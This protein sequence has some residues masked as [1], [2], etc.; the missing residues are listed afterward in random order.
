MSLHLDYSCTIIGEIK[1]IWNCVSKGKHKSGV[2]PDSSG[3]K[4]I[5][6][7]ITERLPW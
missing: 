7:N 6:P 5:N 2:V 1:Y 4:T 3:G